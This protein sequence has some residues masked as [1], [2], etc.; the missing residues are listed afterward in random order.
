MKSRFR[1]FGE[2]YR[3]MKSMGI[4]RNKIKSYI[5]DRMW[6]ILRMVFNPKIPK[7]KLRVEIHVVD[8]CNLNCRGCDNF[9]CIAKPFFWI[10]MNSRRMWHVCAKFLMMML[11]GLH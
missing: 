1:E 6:Q 10:L 9:S 8:H 11:S 5:P 3:W 2:L 7:S 4:I